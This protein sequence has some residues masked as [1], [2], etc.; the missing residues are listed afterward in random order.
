MCSVLLK[1][2]R[3]QTF[4]GQFC[5]WTKLN[6]IRSKVEHQTVLVVWSKFMSARSSWTLPRYSVFTLLPSYGEHCCEEN[7]LAT[8]LQC[9]FARTRTHTRTHART[10]TH[11][12]T[13]L[14]LIFSISSQVVATAL[15][16]ETSP[17]R[18]EGERR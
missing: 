16:A 12:H 3:S 8:L 17:C 13:H 15:S 11:T 18:D 10:H 5:V 1:T 9:T 14:Q 2:S 4:S 7:R 6:L